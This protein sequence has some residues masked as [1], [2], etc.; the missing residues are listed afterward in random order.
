MT[1]KISQISS[2]WHPLTQ[3]FTSNSVV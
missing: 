3:R 2:Y 1:N